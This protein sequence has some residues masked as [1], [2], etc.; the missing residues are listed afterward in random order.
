[1]EV[2]N[3]KPLALLCRS[4]D[5]RTQQIVRVS[6]HRGCA[7]SNAAMSFALDLPSRSAERDYGQDLTDAQPSS[8]KP[9]L[10][11]LQAALLCSRS[12]PCATTRPSRRSCVQTTNDM[13]PQMRPFSRKAVRF[14]RTARSSLSPAQA[15]MLIWTAA[16][17]AFLL[18]ILSLALWVS[19]QQWR[20]PHREPETPWLIHQLKVCG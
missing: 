2:I 20:S 3:N 5:T 7:H 12:S 6:W 10:L 1:M 18:S 14:L 8:P 4:V 11:L 17:V 9:R 15:R 16:T 13:L 19:S